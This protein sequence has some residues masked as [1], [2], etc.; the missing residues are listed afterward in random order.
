MV[1]YCIKEKMKLLID[2]GH[3]AHVHLFKYFAWQMQDRGHNVF[4]TSR[5]KEFTKQLLSDYNFIYDIV[6]KNKS[7]LFLKFINVFKIVFR[8]ALVMYKYKP[9]VTLSH[10]S[11]YL[12]FVAFLFN[13]PHISFENNGNIEQVI[14]YKPFTNV[15]I[16]SQVLQKNYRSKQI[17]INFNH[18]I[19]YLMKKYFTPNQKVFSFLKLNPGE[20]FI[21]IRLVSW[22]ASHDIGIKK[23]NHNKLYNYIFELSK[24]TKIFI[25]SETEIPEILK[26]FEISI[27]PSLI[28][29][30]LYYSKLYLGEGATMASE[31]SCLGTPSV[32]INPIKREYLTELQDYGLLFQSTDL[33]EVKEKV[34]VILNNN[35]NAMIGRLESFLVDKIDVTSFLVWFVEEYPKSFK[36]MKENSDYQYNFK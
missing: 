24:I 4:F 25:S 27:P 7:N 30:V 5:D 11:F 12:A 14:L 36:I 3:P 31:A 2:I 26:E 23:I 32:Y 29:D 19:V 13:K 15:I 9:D 16:T 8:I 28:H 18:E 20:K 33:D 35:N 17:R 21:F 22:A 34:K 6:S 10:G 1:A